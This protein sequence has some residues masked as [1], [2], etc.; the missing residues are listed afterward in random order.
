[1]EY[2]ILGM[3]MIGAGMQMAGGAADANAMEDRA[4]AVAKDAQLRQ[5]ARRVELR[6]QHAQLD[7]GAGASNV[8]VGSASIERQHERA[9]E[10]SDLEQYT[11]DFSSRYRQDAL[12]KGARNAKYQGYVGGMFSLLQGA[13]TAWWMHDSTPKQTKTDATRGHTKIL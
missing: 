6:N 13:T 11:T 3:A 10:L 9:D 4:D 5:T 8:D 7:V 12:N 1:M 2:A